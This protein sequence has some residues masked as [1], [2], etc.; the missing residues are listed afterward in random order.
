VRER[1]EK[2]R[3]AADTNGDGAIDESEWA[4]IR[5]KIE[6]RRAEFDAN[7]DGRLDEAER[8]ALRKSH[9]AEPGAKF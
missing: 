8:E 6:A 9:R 4:A 2:R 1:I 3:A 5:A 7:G